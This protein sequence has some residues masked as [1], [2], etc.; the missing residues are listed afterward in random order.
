MYHKVLIIASAEGFIVKGLETKLNGIGIA[1]LF[2]TFKIADLDGKFENTDLVIMFTDD[3]VTIYSEAYSYIKARCDEYDVEIAVIGTKEEY[4]VLN[5]HISEGYI[6]KLFER[7]IDMEALIED[8]SKYSKD[9]AQVLSKTILIVDDDVS[10]MTMIMNW[11]KDRYRVSMANSGEQALQWLKKNKADLILL[12]YEMP[13]TSGPQVLEMIR[14]DEKIADNP[15][16][17]LTGQSEKESI[18][19]VVALK[20]VGYQLK[21]VDRATLR[22]NIEKFFSKKK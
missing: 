19:K 22:K 10:Y 15:V 1:S 12:D 18:M 17:F 20:P 2:S 16:M 14:S 3:S 13:Q 7:P 8:I 5:S 11:L 6:Y 9:D 21:S 4:A